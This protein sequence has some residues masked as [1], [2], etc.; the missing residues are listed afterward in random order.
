MKL[1][2]TTTLLLITSLCFA[3]R[4]NVYFYKNSGLLVHNRDSADYICVI[5]E[6]DSGSTL[7]NVFEFYPNG[8]SKLLTKSSTI[9]PPTYEGNCIRYFANGKRNGV[10]NYK[11]GKLIGAEYLYYPNGK[12]Y[13]TKIHPDAAEIGKKDYEYIISEYDSLGTALVADSNGYYKGFDDKFK[14]VIE[15][16]NIKSGRHDGKW[17]GMDEGLHVKFTETYDMG[18]FLGGVSVGEHNDSVTYKTRAVEPLFK[19][20]PKAFNEFL[21][22]SIRYPEQERANNVQGKVTVQFV[23]EKDGKVTDAKIVNNVSYNIDEE[24]LRVINSSPKWMP[25]TEYGRLVRVEYTVSFNFALN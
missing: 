22:R 2:I 8:K 21:A 11:G 19:G 17:K 25:G 10:S 4:Q 23:V 1:L 5:S 7:Y 3:Q 6:P 18:K 15:E 24:T 14:N 16:G 12:V 20:G 13:M 9:N